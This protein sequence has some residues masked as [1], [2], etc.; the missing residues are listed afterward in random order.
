MR[1]LL[2]RILIYC[3]VFCILASDSVKAQEQKIT[4]ISR[5]L[6]GAEVQWYP[7]GWLIGPVANYR[8]TPKHILNTRI[9]I[10][11]ANR[12][13]WSGLNDDERGVGYGGSIGYRYL[14]HPSKN[15]FFI[16]TRGDL[17]R[18]VIKWKN[19]PGTPQET[20]GST[21]IIVYQP[22]AELGY[23]LNTA[24]DKLHIVFAG[25]AGK[26][27][28]VKT[29]GREVGQGGMWLLSISMFRIID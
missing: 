2:Y 22:S 8:I 14:F 16:G 15:S 19:K 20:S 25:G 28:N 10:N 5:F 24:H 27:I 23:W 1:A 4:T 17:F 12:H 7:A 3:F 6:A 11:I 29:T 26:E 18:S 9:A 13:N 21:T